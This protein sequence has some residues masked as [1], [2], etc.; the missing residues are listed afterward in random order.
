M[1]QTCDACQSVSGVHQ[2]DTSPPALTLKLCSA[3]LN[4]TSR[5][6]F[7]HVPFSMISWQ[8]HAFGVP[9][10]PHLPFHFPSLFFPCL[11]LSY[12]SIFPVYLE[13]YSH[14]VFV[15]YIYIFFCQDRHLEL[16]F[17]M[18]NESETNL[19]YFTNI[20]PLVFD[21]FCF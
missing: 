16:Y 20:K 7:T 19:K 9:V 12:F 14:H 1:T 15:L 5:I 10:F 6:N 13:A 17:M 11:F 4:A 2:Q 21:S 3:K 8:G 18:K